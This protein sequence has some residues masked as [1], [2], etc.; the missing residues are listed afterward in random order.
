[1]VANRVLPEDAAGAFF[2][3]WR[4]TQ[5]RVLA[6]MEQYF[7][8]V[9]LKRVPMFAQEV[10]GVARLTELADRLYSPGEDPS[11]PLRSERP[12]TFHKADDC[13]EVRVQLPFAAKGE[14]RLFKKGDEL[15]IEIGSLRRHIGLPTSM[16]ALAPRR[17]R[18]DNKI[19]TVELT[20]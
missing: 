12:Y 8:P 1:V 6:E 17:A 2:A 19:L 18:L 16:A 20:A 9:P 14:V 11:L 4:D 13:Y 5:Q 3:P 7:A 10:M 15:V